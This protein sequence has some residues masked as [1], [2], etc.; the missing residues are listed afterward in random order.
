MT[1]SSLGNDVSRLSSRILK[2]AVSSLAASLDDAFGR[3]EI[4]ADRLGG[5]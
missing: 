1:L 2:G 4:L 5:D 3:L